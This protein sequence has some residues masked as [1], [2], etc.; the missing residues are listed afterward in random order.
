MRAQGVKGGGFREGGETE[1]DRAGGA[2][3]DVGSRFEVATDSFEA[4]VVE[5]REAREVQVIVNMLDERGGSSTGVQDED[6]GLALFSE[7]AQGV[8]QVAL[9][10]F[11]ETTAGREIIENQEFSTRDSGQ[12][13]AEIE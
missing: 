8:E 10:A 2:V 4:V 11:E 13:G 6:A 5:E 1:V 7:T 12:S 3:Q 9:A